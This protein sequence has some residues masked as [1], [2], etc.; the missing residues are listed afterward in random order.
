M[1]GPGRIL[2][3]ISFS[4]ASPH[5]LQD[6]HDLLPKHGGHEAVDKH[7]HGRVDG[8]AEVA[9]I[10][11]HKG[12]GGEDVGHLGLLAHVAVLQ[13]EDLMNVDSN[14]RQMAKDEPEDDDQEDHG[15]PI[16]GGAAGFLLGGGGGRVGG[17]LKPDLGGCWSC[18]LFDAEITIN[19]TSCARHELWAIFR[20]R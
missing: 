13:G 19:D 2:K 16:L 3:A 11:A 18:G 7:V 12:P 15:Q 5:A 1:I 17:G 6:L 10:H 9:D 14:P 4:A 20:S 8:Q